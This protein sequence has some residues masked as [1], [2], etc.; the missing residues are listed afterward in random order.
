[1][2]NRCM[3]LQE[4]SPSRA[5]PNQTCAGGVCQPRLDSRLAIS[6]AWLSGYAGSAGCR[7]IRVIVGRAARHLS[8]GREGNRFQPQYRTRANPWSP[9]CNSVATVIAINAS[10]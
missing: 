1:M 3:V 4:A 10:V 9:R 6:P 2:T 8:G 5:H 7:A